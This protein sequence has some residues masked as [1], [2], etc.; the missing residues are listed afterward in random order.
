MKSLLSFLRMHGDHEPTPNPS[1]EGNFR[2]ADECLLPSWEG[3]GVGRFMESRDKTPGVRAYIFRRKN[4]RAGDS[5]GMLH[6][7]RELVAVKLVILSQSFK[8]MLVCRV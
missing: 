7:W 2:A 4:P 5:N 3:S 6:C 1:Q 8:F